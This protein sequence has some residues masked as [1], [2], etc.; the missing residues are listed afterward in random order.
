MNK[1]KTTYKLLSRFG[2]SNHSNTVPG[3]VWYIWPSLSVL[4]IRDFNKEVS[5]SLSWLCFSVYFRV[6]K[7]RIYEQDVSTE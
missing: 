1:L 5:V 7:L 4:Y 3:A 6:T 2:F